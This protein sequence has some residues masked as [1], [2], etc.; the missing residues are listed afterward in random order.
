MNKKKLIALFLGWGGVALVCVGAFYLASEWQEPSYPLKKT[1]QYS[2]NVT[3][4]TSSVIEDVDVFIYGPVKRTSN[5]RVLKIDASHPYEITVD[6]HLNQL[7]HFN[8]KRVAPHETRIIRIKSDLEMSDKP[9]KFALVDTGA[10]LGEEELLQT[11]ASAIQQR[12]VKLRADTSIATARN[13]YKWV[14]DNIEYTGYISED[15]GALYAI[16]TKKGD[17]TEYASLYSALSRVNDI[18][19]R[20]IGGFVL[21]GSAKLHARDYHNWSESYIENKWRIADP[22]KQNF[23]ERESRYVAMRVIAGQSDG[24]LSSS[25]HFAYSGSDLDISMN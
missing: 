14:S 10:Y 18:P 20:R 16:N 21:A 12:A 22:Q 7:L 1:V 19:S 5:Q 9:N 15:R 13:L 17:C 11:K 25:H 6:D 24:L 23:Q 3:N 8:F 4:K 2:F